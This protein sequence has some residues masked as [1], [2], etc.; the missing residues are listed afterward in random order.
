M[1]VVELILHDCGICGEYLLLDS[2]AVAQHLKTGGHNI[3]HANY[4]AQY[5]NSMMKMQQ[6]PPKKNLH[7]FL[8]RSKVEA[9]KYK[10]NARK[11]MIMRKKIIR[12]LII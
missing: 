8:K 2:D 6:F 3:T 7:N 4:N 10:P 9:K 5:M 11:L 12:K 1:Y